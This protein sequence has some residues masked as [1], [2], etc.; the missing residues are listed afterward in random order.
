MRPFRRMMQAR[1]AAANRA[2]DWLADE[3]EMRAVPPS[4]TDPR[5]TQW[6]EPHMVFRGTS[7]APIGHLVVFLAGSLGFPTRQT[8]FPR[9][10]A[11]MGYHVIN[12]RYANSIPIGAVCRGSTDPH[13]HEKA[14]LH[15]AEGLNS[16]LL[17]DVREQDCILS[18]LTRLLGFLSTNHP[19]E[20]WDMFCPTFGL[21]WD[22]I[23]VAGHSQ[24]GG[25]AALLG[26]RYAC[27]R[28][29]MFAAPVDDD[30]ISG[31]SAAWLS[32]PGRTAPERFFGFVHTNDPGFDRI[33]NAWEALGLAG[34]GGPVNVDKSMP[35][36][37]NSHQLVTARPALRDRFHASVATDGP[38][39]RDA[40]DAPLFEPVW[41][42]MLESAT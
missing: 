40:N 41:R 33:L 11:S 17:P 18:R 12:L 7:V 8:L 20:G 31:Q 5:I 35:P 14:R 1:P 19:G 13:C 2:D 37:A 21:A 26:K 34:F 15:I 42:W 38:T 29:L 6:T 3:T 4:D 25:H 24:G 23:L 22:R 36:Y 39:P 30:G 28:I 27:R 32:A 16:G 10:A 9:L